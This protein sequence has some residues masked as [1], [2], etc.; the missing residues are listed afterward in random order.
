MITKMFEHLMGKP[1][2]DYIDDMVVKSKQEP[3]HL[4]DLA[5]VFAIL[6]KHQLRQNAAKCAFRVSSSKFL[7]HLVTQ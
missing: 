1:M 5:E 4:K 6:K 2:D 3:N 7:G